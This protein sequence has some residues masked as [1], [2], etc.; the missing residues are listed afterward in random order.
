MY[1]PWHRGQP[2]KHAGIFAYNK[3]PDVV[4]HP[5]IFGILHLASMYWDMLFLAYNIVLKCSQCLTCSHHNAI[6][7][8]HQQGELK[9]NERI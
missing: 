5:G 2:E 6:H 3:R 9:A 7:M 8:Y 4:G 1:L